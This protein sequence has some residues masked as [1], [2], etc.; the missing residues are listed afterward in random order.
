MSSS[1]KKMLLLTKKKVSFPP[2]TQMP[3]TKPWCRKKY[4]REHPGL[5]VVAPLPHKAPDG[6][7][8]F[9]CEIKYEVE[10]SSTLLF[11]KIGIIGGTNRKLLNSRSP[12]SSE[13]C[14][15]MLSSGLC[16]KGSVTETAEAARPPPTLRHSR[17][18]PMPVSAPSAQ[19]QPLCPRLLHPLIREC[20]P[21]PRQCTEPESCRESRQPR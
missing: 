21:G 12:R 9:A 4:T 6:L 3:C 8:L 11:L 1:L 16:T 14:Q 5:G 19:A 15:G 17:C 2:E 7:Y 20:V 13:K 18:C 10:D